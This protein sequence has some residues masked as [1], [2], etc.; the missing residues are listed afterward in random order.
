MSEKKSKQLPSEMLENLVK[1]T[2][3][4]RK[5][6]SVMWAKY[7]VLNITSKPGVAKSAIGRS[8]ADKMD[9]HIQIFVCRW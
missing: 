5:Y 2:A 8:I 6:F 1:L 9:L 4:E 3:K 7:G